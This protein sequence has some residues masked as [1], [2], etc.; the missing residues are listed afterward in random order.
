L[1]EKGLFAGKETGM[2]KEIPHNSFP[3][4]GKRVPRLLLAETG[5][6]KDELETLRIAS[7]FCEAGYEVIYLGCQLTPE[8]IYS[9]AIQEGVDLIGLN[10]ISGENGVSSQ[11]VIQVFK[12]RKVE[13][14][15]LNRSVFPILSTSPR[16][17]ST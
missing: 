9:A 4:S 2:S 16:C 13:C 10:L 8:Q 12:E 1:I 14:I 3:Q 17:K 6:L 5:P 11:Q 7:A 15:I